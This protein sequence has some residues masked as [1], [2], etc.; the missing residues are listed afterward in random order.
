MIPF[1]T[2]LAVGGRF[3]IA[4]ERASAYVGQWGPRKPGD[5]NCD[6]RTDMLDLAELAAHWLQP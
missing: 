5:L 1:Y 3:T 2:H 4:G 6:G